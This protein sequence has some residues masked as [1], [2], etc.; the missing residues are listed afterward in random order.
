MPGAPPDRQQD[1]TLVAPVALPRC[2]DA[3]KQSLTSLSVGLRPVALRVL[4]TG[5]YPTGPPVAPAQIGLVERIADRVHYL[6]DRDREVAFDLN[7]AYILH[8]CLLA[9]GLPPFGAARL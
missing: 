9:F 3:F 1:E 2:G 7:A 4:G 6:L 5:H 8:S